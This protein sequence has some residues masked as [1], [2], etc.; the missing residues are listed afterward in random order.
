[1]LRL[2]GLRL[3]AFAACIACVVAC[4]NK[5]IAQM[6]EQIKQL[7]QMQEQIRQHEEELQQLKVQVEALNETVSALQGAVVQMQSLSYVTGV[8]PDIRDGVTY[9]LMTHGYGSVKDIKGS[10]ISGVIPTDALD[11]SYIIYPRFDRDKCVG[12]GR[13]HI[14]CMD[15][16]HQAIEFRDGRPLLRA[17]RCVGCHLCVLVCPKGAI[18]SSE[19]KVPKRG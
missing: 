13:C 8:A 6:Q 2:R 4:N 12:C 3:L 1:M 19:I 5:E 10:T 14:S 11:R 18:R 17:D 9:F 16:G 7:E 15:G